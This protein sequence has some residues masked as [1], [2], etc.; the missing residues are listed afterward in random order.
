MEQ[1]WLRRDPEPGTPENEFKEEHYR[2]IAFADRH[3]GTRS[4]RPGWQSDRGHLSIIYGPPDEID[5]HPNPPQGSYPFEMWRYNHVEGI[6]DNLYFHFV[7]REKTGDYRL[8]PGK[9]I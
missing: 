9:P 5:S 6:G 3:F 7:D 1:F 8:A 2:R 4:G